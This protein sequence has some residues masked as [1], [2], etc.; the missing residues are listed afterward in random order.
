MNKY[1]I[2]VSYSLRVCSTQMDILRA[3]GLMKPSHSLFPLKSNK[4]DYSFS[5]VLWEARQRRYRNAETASASPA[6]NE[7]EKRQRIKDLV[8]EVCSV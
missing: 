5:S 1:A 2:V 6:K 4:G 7:T 8:F 3:L